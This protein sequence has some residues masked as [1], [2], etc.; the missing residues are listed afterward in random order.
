MKAAV[1]FS[2]GG[3]EVVEIA[4]VP[5]PEVG[6]DDALIRVHAV[7]LNHLDLFVRRGLPGR[8]LPMPHIGGSDVA[9][10]VAGF[11]SNVMGLTAGQRVLVNP[12]LSCGQCEF[13]Q[14]GQ[15]SL[16]VR[17]RILGEHTRGGMAEYVAV[18][19]GNVLPIPDDLSWEEAAAVPLVFQTAWRALMSQAR[20]RQGQDVLILGASGGA[21]TAAIQIA[22][23]V[24]ARV[25]AVTSTPFVDR[26]LSL[27]ADIVINRDEADFSREAWQLTDKRGVDVV[28]ENTGAATWRQSL[29]AL[30]K[31]GRLVTYGATTGPIG[32]TD[33]RIIFWKQLHI[34]GS[35]MA[36][37]REFSQVMDL[38][39]QGKLRPVIDRVLPLD[40]ARQAHE[41]LEAGQ[42]FGKIV[43]KVD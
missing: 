36:N 43:L 9:G 14:Q 15:E 10:Q 6:P 2:H 28:L 33:I 25:F 42:Q 37:R 40:Q 22:K 13:C 21:A 34:I 27:G 29:R 11:G 30:A 32:E 20:L 3:P 31:G 7:A 23:Y 38:V 17:F 12:A 26:V 5:V 1:F 8:E 24:G 35:T 18:P 41:I 16:C 4:E 39:F 19:A